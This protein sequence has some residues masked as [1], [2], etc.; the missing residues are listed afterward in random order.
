MK[1]LS[2]LG[3]KLSKKKQARTG[4][5]FGR[6]SQEGSRINVQSWDDYYY[7]RNRKSEPKSKNLQKKADNEEEENFIWINLILYKN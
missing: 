7:K 4:Y 2:K 3:K 1:I 6:I 5:V